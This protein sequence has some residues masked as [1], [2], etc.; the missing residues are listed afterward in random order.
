MQFNIIPR[1]LSPRPGK[2][3]EIN[4]VKGTRFGGFVE[5]WFGEGS[6]N[7]SCA[8]LDCNCFLARCLAK[9][10]PE[11]SGSVFVGAHDSQNSNRR[12]RVGGIEG[13][14]VHGQIVVIDFEEE[15]LAI[16]LDGTEIVLA[17]GIIAPVKAVESFERRQ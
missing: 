14:L 5:P 1:C 4:K 9:K 15:L 8:T 17:V 2:T 7:K 16:D 12:V 11:V 6:R 13:V 10:E 3:T